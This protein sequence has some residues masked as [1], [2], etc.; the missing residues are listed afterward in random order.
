MYYILE[1]GRLL[2]GDKPENMREVTM[3]PGHIN[4][5]VEAVKW[6]LDTRR[7]HK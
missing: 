7:Q 2:H 3:V 6:H 4:T 1:N 5:L